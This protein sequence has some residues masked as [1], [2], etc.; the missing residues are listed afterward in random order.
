MGEPADQARRPRRLGGHL[1]RG[2][3][4]AEL[5]RREISRLLADDAEPRRM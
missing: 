1:E 2:E 3:A 4:E 5:R